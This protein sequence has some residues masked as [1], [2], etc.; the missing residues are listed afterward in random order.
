MTVSITD[1]YSLIRNYI[2]NIT[3]DNDE[4]KEYWMMRLRI[5]LTGKFLTFQTKA[6][7]LTFFIGPIAL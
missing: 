4:R 1:E 7:Y 3:T 5:Y 6:V 2:L